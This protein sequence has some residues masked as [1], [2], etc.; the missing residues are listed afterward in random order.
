MP[1]FT[2]LYDLFVFDL[3]GTL[4]DT[5]V[6]IARSVNY[7]LSR[8]GLPPLEVPVVTRYVG[9]GARVLMERA[10]GSRGAQADLESALRDFLAHYREHCL[11]STT[12]YPGVLEALRGLRGEGKW[13]AVLTNKPLDPTKRILE[14]LGVLSFF[15]RIEGGDSAPARKPDPSGL[16]GIAGELGCDRS[17][18]LVVGDSSVDVETARAAGAA[19]A[20]VV[21]GF[22]SLAPGQE[23]DYRLERIEELLGSAQRLS[24]EGA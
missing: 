18:T 23:P 10:L 4:A 16:L 24:G 3:D 6:D 19:A 2:D 11:D 8:Q 21:Y 12:L 22:G 9:N 13:L 15:H 5:R 20:V 14:A 7:A 1:R 17:R